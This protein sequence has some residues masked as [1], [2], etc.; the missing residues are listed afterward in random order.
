M[1]QAMDAFLGYPA[2]TSVAYDP[3]ADP[4][5]LVRGRERGLLR[6]IYFLP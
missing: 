1:R 3:R 6:C 2:V 4:T 5:R